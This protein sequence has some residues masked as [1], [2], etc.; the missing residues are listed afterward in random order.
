MRWVAAVS[1]CDRRGML[2]PRLLVAL[3]LVVAVAAPIAA[4]D[5]VQAKSA[6]E[7]V[8]DG[9][10][11]GRDGQVFRLYRAF[12]LRD[13]DGD[14]VRYWI[15]QARWNGRSMVTIAQAFADSEEFQQR[16]GTLGDAG[17][18]D[19]V[20]RNV[21]GRTADDDGRA[22]WLDQLA[23]GMP[24][25]EMMLNFSESVEF[26]QNVGAG[27]FGA[28]D[29]RG[30]A[31]PFLAAA[32]APYAFTEPD[33]NG[34]GSPRR[35]VPCRTVYVVTNY[36]GVPSSHH[37]EADAALERVLAQI[38]DASRTHWVH[39]GR[40]QHR[41]QGRSQGAPP[42]LDPTVFISFPD[43]TAAFG[44]ALGFGGYTT[45]THPAFG[46][47]KT[48]GSVQFNRARLVED[49]GMR[50]SYEQT[51]AHELGHVAGLAHVAEDTG[52]IMEPSNTVTTTTG[53]NGTTVE[54][55]VEE[56]GTGDLAGL[57]RLGSRDVAC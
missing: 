28:V 5:A 53:P 48:S 46:L 37:A 12:F 34:P 44:G 43:D 13:P 31:T 42:T 21:L 35:W 10:V 57:S 50:V 52:Q 15:G 40:T 3:V 54:V 47:V 8:Y 49:D 18:V 9:S 1:V 14:G 51:L 55:E 39:V 11:D 19:L 23:R 22:Y 26:G 32:G 56:Y 38:S 45:A 29:Y 17:F 20:Y 16:Y 4:P 36:Q 33:G 7:I 25:G 24:R 6:S 30:P 2:R 41:A 27:P